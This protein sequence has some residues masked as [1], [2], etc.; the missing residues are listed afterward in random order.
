MKFLTQLFS[1]DD[2]APTHRLIYFHGATRGE[3]PGS[4]G[5][6]P[7]EK[8]EAASEEAHQEAEKLE[9]DFELKALKKSDIH[10]KLLKQ[11]AKENGMTTEEL[12]ALN[13]KNSPKFRIGKTPKGSLYCG[14]NDTV[15]VKKPKGES[16]LP[17]SNP[18]E[19]TRTLRREREERLERKRVEAVERKEDVD[20]INEFQADSYTARYKELVGKDAKLPDFLRGNKNRTGNEDWSEMLRLSQQADSPQVNRL[21]DVISVKPLSLTP[22]TFREMIRRGAPNVLSFNDITQTVTGESA[23]KFT[24]KYEGL[25]AKRE[26]GDAKDPARLEQVI[27][28]RE[29]II[30]QAHKIFQ[31]MEEIRGGQLLDE[32]TEAEAAAASEEVSEVEKVGTSDLF[33]L[34]AAMDGN[35]DRIVRGEVKESIGLNP[36]L[37]QGMRNALEGMG[38]DAAVARRADIGFTLQVLLQC[39]GVEE[40]ISNGSISQ[41]VS[42]GKETILHLQA[43]P[44]DFGPQNP[45]AQAVADSLKVKGGRLVFDKIAAEN[46]QLDGLDDEA[47]TAEVLESTFRNTRET[48]SW[49]DA[50]A[51]ESVDYEKLRYAT[52]D[53]DTEA[54]LADLLNYRRSFDENGEEVVDYAALGEDLDYFLQVGIKEYVHDPDI[55]LVA[56]L[57]KAK[58]GVPAADKT[59]LANLDLGL[60]DLSEN[61]NKIDKRIKRL[62]GKVAKMPGAKDFQT[63]LEY[64]RGEKVKE[65]TQ[66]DDL[67]AKRETILDKG[68][69]VNQLLSALAI[70][71]ENLGA[72]TSQQKMFIQNGYE[73]RGGRRLAQRVKEDFTQS[74]ES[75]IAHYEGKE[76][77]QM[78]LKAIVKQLEKSGKTI[79]PDM[80]DMAA[81]HIQDAIDHDGFKFDPVPDF[82]KPGAA[83]TVG[84]AGS[85]ESRGNEGIVAGKLGAALSIPVKISDT[86]TMNVTLT[87]G[88]ALS[89]EGK[90]EVGVGLGTGKSWQIDDEV[91]IGVSAGAGITLEGVGGGAAFTAAEQ[92]GDFTHF[93]VLSAGVGLEPGGRLTPGAAISFGF[94]KRPESYA[95]NARSVAEFKAGLGDVEK[96]GLS[97]AEKAAEIAKLPEFENLVQ[98]LDDVG[99]GK[100]TKEM[101]LLDAYEDFKKT[102]GDEAEANMSVSPISGASVTMIPVPPFII[103]AISF[104]FR[105]KTKTYFSVENMSDTLEGSGQKISDALKE[106]V[107]DATILEDPEMGD[108]VVDP[109]PS[110][111]NLEGQRVKVESRQTQTLSVRDL[112]SKSLDAQNSAISS[113][114]FHLENGSGDMDGFLNLQVNGVRGNVE[115][116]MDPAMKSRLV[117]KPGENGKATGKDIHVALNQLNPDSNLLIT[118]ETFVMPRKRNG[119]YTYTRITI[120][121]NPSRSIADIRKE[122]HGM[123]AFRNNSNAETFA[124]QGAGGA[125]TNVLQWNNIDDAYEQAE[126]F[127][128]LDMDGYLAELGLVGEPSLRAAAAGPEAI[129]P[130]NK[131]SDLAKE[132]FEKDVKTWLEESIFDE[133]WHESRIDLV[134]KLQT[135]AKGL[136]P[137]VEI[138]Q[139]QLNYMISVIRKLTYVASDRTTQEQRDAYRDRNNMFFEQVL[140]ANFSPEVAEEILGDIEGNET[141]RGLPATAQVFTVVGRKGVMGLRADAL[142]G[143]AEVLGYTDYSDDLEMR[144][145]IL[146]RLETLT[147]S[148]EKSLRTTLALNLYEVYAVVQGVGDYN[149]MTEIYENPELIATSDA[150]TEAYNQ[151]MEILIKLQGNQASGAMFEIKTDYG[152]TLE[153]GTQTEVF[154][155]ALSYCDNPTVGLNQKIA[156]GG[157]QGMTATELQTMLPKIKSKV[158]TPIYELFVAYSHTHTKKPPETTPHEEDEGGTS[159]TG[160]QDEPVDGEDAPSDSDTESSP[161][162]DGGTVN[163]GG[164]GEESGLPEGTLR[165]DP[166]VLGTDTGPAEGLPEGTLRDAPAYKPDSGSDLPKGTLQPNPDVLGTDTG[167]AEGL[168]T[169]TFKPAPDY[170]KAPKSDLPTGTLKPNPDVLGDQTGPAEGLPEGTLEP[171]PTPKAPDSGLPTGT[172]EEN[173]DVLGDQTGPAEGLP[174]GTLKPAPEQEG[175]GYDPG[176][177]PRPTDDLPTGTLEENPDVLGDQTGPAEGL[178]EGQLEPVPTPKDSG[179]P[180]GTLEENPDVLGTSTDDGPASGLPTGTLEENPDVLGDQTGPAEGLPEGQLEPVPT[181]KDS[182]LPTGTLEENPDVLGDQTGPA[183]G[184]PEGQLEPVPTPKDSG[185]P[186]GTLEENPDVLGDQTGP[187]EG[188]PEG[189]LEPVPTPKASGLPTG[190]LE[191]NPDVL[192]T[193][194]DDGPASGLP[195]GTLEENPDVLGTSTDDTPAPETPG[196]AGGTADVLNEGA[197]PAPKLQGAIPIPT[198]LENEEEENE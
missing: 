18:A 180:T 111:Y 56:E 176:N 82:P 91:T 48:I 11:I 144:Q 113:S 110:G 86:E 8:R 12:V 63:R 164:G 172:L 142:P 34:D 87:A 102:I 132:V 163:P 183:E 168:P 45:M 190:T 79:D 140:S 157:F 145:A 156:I 153:L 152:I 196:E 147:D 106:K 107:A 69:Y 13:K 124:P 72:L 35:L 178:P 16:G 21:V 184:L 39:Y 198:S 158:S 80:L 104:Q 33:D 10:H 166:N 4:G 138:N 85:T 116:Y 71:P 23:Q 119:A 100:K 186:T 43:M 40:L 31:A 162:S 187:A 60:R 120:K 47:R 74:V 61:M 118:R 165:E 38:V 1:D 27:A 122:P 5:E 135:A 148:P 17:K 24:E 83:P 70:D 96:A 150:H 194:T 185:L 105:G 37:V 149:L 28:N 44:G 15:Y 160:E 131:L 19:R 136:D 66:I 93:Q 167:P 114:G 130:D 141:H 169:G 25:L 58:V 170:G 26:A 42:S 151:F 84:L 89:H 20:S 78:G 68:D 88:V 137:A 182:G 129:D 121:D 64:A 192:G 30:V 57:G 117:A 22:P 95:E 55:N 126:M 175:T 146:D 174:E 115:I 161:D 188:L 81:H 101:V 133:D 98:E 109:S 36:Q 193:S 112:L 62:E 46:M 103:P 139:D 171:V 181:P 73:R 94:K 2:W 179:L 50:E 90:T 52:R 99:M 143:D 67:K 3:A 77:I 134:E 41:K 197:T 97:D 123:I 173:P 59:E 195:T 127:D 65:Q 51:G 159:D 92:D 7:A 29:A 9:Q 154:G 177:K 75:V 76:I 49:E 6:S 191:E 189:Q 125:L 53:Q 54:M 14:E 128:D 32:T 108:W 155:G